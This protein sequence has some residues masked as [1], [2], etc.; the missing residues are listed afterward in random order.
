MCARFDHPLD[1]AVFRR[2]PRKPGVQML[3]T[4]LTFA[5]PNIRLCWQELPQAPAG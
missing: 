4:H 2:F 3:T 1:R 5:V